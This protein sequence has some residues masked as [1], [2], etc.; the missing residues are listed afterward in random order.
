MPVKWISNK[1]R[2]LIVVNDILS[3]SIYSDCRKEDSSFFTISG[4][5]DEEIFKTKWFFIFIKWPVIYKNHRQIAAQALGYSKYIAWRS[6]YS[7]NKSREGISV[8]FGW[9]L[10]TSDVIGDCWQ[11]WRD[12]IVY[13]HNL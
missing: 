13:L 4:Q 3:Y 10:P 8:M 9:E 11:D 5:Y 12:K 7:Y 6:I 1:R 2:N